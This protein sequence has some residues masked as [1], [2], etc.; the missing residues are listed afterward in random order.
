M[1]GARLRR[2][3][4]VFMTW[5]GTNLI[6]IEITKVYI[7]IYIIRIRRIKATIKCSSDNILPR[8]CSCDPRSFIIQCLLGTLSL[9]A[10]SILGTST[11]PYVFIVWYLIK[12]R[13]SITL[14]NNNIFILH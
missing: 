5:T 7:Y 10:W 6:L 14:N 8:L 3:L 12:H 9:G 11:P 4:Y 13:A 2:L 1:S